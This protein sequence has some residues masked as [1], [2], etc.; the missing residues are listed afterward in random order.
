MIEFELEG[1]EFIELNKL[2]KI[3]GLVGTGGEANTFIVDG[4]VLVNGAVETQKRKKLR[5]GDVVQFQG[6]EVKIT[7]A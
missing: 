6:Q 3:T 4:E 7:K 2:L 1:Y 5:D